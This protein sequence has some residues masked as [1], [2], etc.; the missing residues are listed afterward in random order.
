M[1]RIVKIF[2]GLLIIGLGAAAA[3]YFLAN[4]PTV[5]RQK[6]QAKATPVDVVIA[7]LSET[8]ATIEAMGTVVPSQEITLRSQ[9]SGHVVHIAEGFTPGGRLDKGQTAVRI[10]PRDFE[11]EV[12]KAR[13]S[14][15]RARADLRLE[16]GKQEVARQELDMFRQGSE[17]AIME[18]DLALRRP[19]LEQAQ[20]EVSGS[21]SDLDQAEL[22]LSRTRVTAPFSAL[23]MEQNID[24]GSY[25]SSQDSLATLAGTETYWVRAPVPVDSLEFLDQKPE[26]GSPVRI[27]S[28]SGSGEWTGRTLR[29]TGEVDEA[30]RMATLILAVP[31]PLDQQVYSSPLMLNDYVQVFIQGKT[32]AEVF[33]LPR[34]ALRSGQK[35]WV[36][37]DGQ[38]EIRSVQVIWK[39]RERVYVRQGL[40][41]G[42]KVI[43]SSLATP[44]QGMRLRVDVNGDQE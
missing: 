4:K 41:P 9:V 29:L 14:L 8:T 20:A 5:S 25:V 22:D 43:L 17:L 40:T 16:Q 10:D 6:P 27:V 24:L 3:M 32:L 26:G 21:R 15:A 37:E 36:V 19:Q 34:R 23:V 13:S 11:I 30:T 12:D 2:L 33:S 7:R 35:V 31:K 38:L 28:Q 44:V 18:T 1:N 39:D 42:D